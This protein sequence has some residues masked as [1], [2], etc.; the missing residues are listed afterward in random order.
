MPHDRHYKHS[1]LRAVVEEV[2]STE[3]SSEQRETLRELYSQVCTTWR[4][5]M[6]VRFKLLG[7]VPFVTGSCSA[8]STWPGSVRIA[9]LMDHEDGYDILDFT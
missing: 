6:D 9:L 2:D 8:E 1:E 3:L 7:L 4:A 5:L